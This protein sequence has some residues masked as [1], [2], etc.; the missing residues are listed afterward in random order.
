MEPL[1]QSQKSPR[2]VGGYHPPGFEPTRGCRPRWVRVPDR[3]R[4]DVQHRKSSGGLEQGGKH[5]A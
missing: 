1:L 3:Q 4:R 5:R 2:L